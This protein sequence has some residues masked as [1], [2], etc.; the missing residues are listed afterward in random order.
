MLHILNVN[1]KKKNLISKTHSSV[2][3]KICALVLCWAGVNCPLT[4]AF[5]NSGLDM[6]ASSYGN[7]CLFVRSR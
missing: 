1:T 6:R 4:S 5:V 2:D 3:R 7:F